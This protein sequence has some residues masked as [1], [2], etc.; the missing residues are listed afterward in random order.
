MPLA[1]APD[2]LWP[3]VQSCLGS[4]GNDLAQPRPAEK[5]WLRAAV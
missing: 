3:L 1:D 5:G 4:L 2:P